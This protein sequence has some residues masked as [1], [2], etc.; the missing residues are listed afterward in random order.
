MSHP[1]GLTWARDWARTM[2]VLVLLA[3]SVDGHAMQRI[4]PR[5]THAR[6]STAHHDKAAA[7]ALAR[8]VPSGHRI[9]DAAQ[10]PLLGSGTS[11]GVLVVEPQP[12]QADTSGETLPRT[13]LLIAPDARGALRLMAANKRIV[14]CMRCG[15]ML[16]DPYASTRIEPGRVTLGVSGGSRGVW[17]NAYTFVYEP[18]ADRFVVE[19]VV[20]RV[21][22]RLTG[23]AAS[24]VTEALQPGVITFPE[25]DPD[26][27]GDAPTLE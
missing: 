21:A 22:D 24:A 1:S 19:R 11:G 8:F 15:G 25:F 6:T 7:L 2:S 27:L 9:V 18:A 3:C 14:P 12:A 13:V 16:G 20:R 17:S 23:A 10:G 26:Q 4:A 5:A